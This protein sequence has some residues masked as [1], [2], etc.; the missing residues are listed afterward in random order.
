SEEVVVEVPAVEGQPATEDTEEVPAVPAHTAVVTKIEMSGMAFAYLHYD[1]E[2][3]DG[4][5]EDKIITGIYV[6]YATN[7][8]AFL[9]VGSEDTSVLFRFRLQMYTDEETG[10]ESYVAEL[11]DMHYFGTFVGE[12]LT[13][14][15]LNGFTGAYYVDGYGR[16]Y[17]GQF[18]VLESDETSALIEIMYID[19]TEYTVKY[20]YARLDFA[21]GTFVVAAAPEEND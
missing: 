4:E 12:D 6:Q 7:G 17:G 11:A 20:T 5:I 3:E 19:T 18:T 21:N 2:T 14:I 15:N 1:Y 10:E 9:M 16:V 13:V 8:F